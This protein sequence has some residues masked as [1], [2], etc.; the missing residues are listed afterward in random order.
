MD[1]F[2]YTFVLIFF[3]QIAETVS[4]RSSELDFKERGAFSQLELTILE[5]ENYKVGLTYT[6]SSLN[7][8]YQDHYIYDRDM[9][10]DKEIV[11][12]VSLF[13]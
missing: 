13:S 7:R 9:E 1:L 11:R 10:N 2:L 5:A 4:W 8:V 3:L 6:S 12:L